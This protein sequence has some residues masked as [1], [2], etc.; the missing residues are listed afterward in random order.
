MDI[1]CKPKKISTKCSKCNA[2]VEDE[3]DSWPSPD[4]SA[5]TAS[6]SRDCIGGTLVCPKCGNEIDYSISDD[7]NGDII[8]IP[9]DL[10]IS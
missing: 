5:E 3:L 2:T 4:F 9:S 1:T 8:C 7:F 10:I 6:E